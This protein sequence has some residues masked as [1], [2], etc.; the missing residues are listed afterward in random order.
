MRAFLSLILLA[1]CGVLS[2]ASCKSNDIA[3]NNT[4][5]TIGQQC[6]AAAAG[7]DSGSGNACAGGV[8]T[9]SYCRTACTTDSQCMGAVCISGPGGRGCQVDSELKCDASRPCM[10]PG[11]V[12]GDDGT[13]RN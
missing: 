5:T 10:T 3:A 7:G 12:C 9:V 2:F 1:L 13:C 6:N 4:T 11:L 8:C